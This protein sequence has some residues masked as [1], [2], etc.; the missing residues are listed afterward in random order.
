MLATFS[1]MTDAATTE[2]GTGRA[3]LH[4]PLDADRA[5]R[6]QKFIVKQ[7]PYFLGLLG[8]RI[9][10]LR[11]DYC[12]MRLPH[13]REVMQPAGL[14]HGGA[15]ATLLDSVVVPAIGAAYGP[16]ARYSTVD[17]HVQYIGALVDDD[18][19]AEGWVVKRGR[20]LVFAESEAVAATSG[21]LLARASLTF[22]VAA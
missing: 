15:I 8:I 19:V 10:D 2:P 17:F 5:E 1:S 12:R 11:V 20:S 18:A 16:G 14:V 3:A 22:S 13:R 21:S 9:E 7:Q 6:W 4:A